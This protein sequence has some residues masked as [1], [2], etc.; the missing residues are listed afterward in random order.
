[1]RTAAK[2][3]RAEPLAYRAEFMQGRRGT[4]LPVRPCSHGR[5]A[6]HHSRRPCPLPLLR[7]L[8]EGHVLQRRPRGMR[9]NRRAAG[10]LAFVDIADAS[11]RRQRVLLNHSGSRRSTGGVSRGDG[12]QGVL[13]DELQAR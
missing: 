10:G 8:E 2:H 7:E 1:M 3:M 11:N 9:F 4:H 6:T 5:H 13:H 12:P